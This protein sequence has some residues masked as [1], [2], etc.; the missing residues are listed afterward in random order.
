MLSQPTTK[1]LSR[2][3]RALILL[4]FF[5]S[6]ISGLIYEVVWVR[7]L[8]Y[9]FG[10]SLLAV[11]TVLAAYMGGLAL[12]S[13]LGGRYVDRHQ[14][15]LRLYAFL[16]IGIGISALLLLW[17]INSLDPFYVWIYER[18]HASFMTFSLLR[19]AI[20]FTLLLV[21]TTLMGATLPILSRFLVRERQ[22]IGLDVGN[23]YALNTSGAV[24]GCFWTG[25]Y[26]IALFGLRGVI[27]I[28]VAINIIV[29][30][31][32]LWLSYQRAFG[33]SVN[34]LE[35]QKP[36]PDDVSGEGFKYPPKVVTALLIAYGLSGMSALGYQ[37]IWTRTLPFSFEW[38]RSTTYSFTA[39]LTVFLVGLFI[40][41]ALMSYFS[42]RTKNPL[43]IF[44][45]IQ[46]SIGLTA[47]SSLYLIAFVT[48]SFS[49]LRYMN[50]DTGLV[51]WSAS[52]LRLTDL[53]I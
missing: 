40:G 12:G 32:A 3:H 27:Y 29:G 2:K 49:P 4:L 16:E 5:S 33:S 41:S 18:S 42:A 48:P 34:F 11:S 45:Y 9:I 31:M 37:V 10:T 7:Q 22:G 39:M 25:F 1:A 8:T 46:F 23:L 21:P 28:A 13:W 44:S 53:Y 24:M 52:A 47:V 17:M 14:K 50:Q 6:G 36:N 51:N 15:P 26:G 43:G 19:F 20:N 35:D 38:A 30:L